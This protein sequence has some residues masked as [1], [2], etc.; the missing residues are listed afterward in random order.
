MLAEGEGTG[1]SPGAPEAGL[2]PQ[3]GG[4]PAEPGGGVPGLGRRYRYS[5]AKASPAAC[6]VW[7]M[8]PWVW[9]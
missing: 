7:S 5:R 9:A 6:T 2:L 4:G 8:S 1:N 3:S